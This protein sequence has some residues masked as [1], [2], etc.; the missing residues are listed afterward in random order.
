MEFI[1]KLEKKVLGWV[2]GVPHLPVEGQK[3]LAENMWWM[4]LVLAI[5][6]GVNFLYTL[7]ALVTQIDLIGSA[8]SSYYISSSFTSL[9]I[10]N[11]VIKLLL[12]GITGLLLALAVKPLQVRSKKGWVLLFI[13]LLVEALWVVVHAALSLNFSGFIVSMLFGVVG[14]EIGAIVLLVCAY[15]VFEVHSQF[16]HSVKATAKKAE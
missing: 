12:V 11:L 13:I 9:S 4:V 15:F 3:W 7:A 2:K 14:G 5:I 8:S 6:S 16:G 10:V 1:T